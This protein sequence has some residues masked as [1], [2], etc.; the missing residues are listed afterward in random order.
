MPLTNRATL[1]HLLKHFVNVAKYKEDNKMDIGNL[2]L[3]FGPTLIWSMDKTNPGSLTVVMKKQSQLV[4]QLCDIQNEIFHDE[5][6]VDPKFAQVLHGRDSHYHSLNDLRN[7][8][9]S[10]VTKRRKTSES[11][12]RPVTVHERFVFD[13]VKPQK[14]VDPSNTIGNMLK[15]LFAKRSSPHDLAKRGI[16][17]SSQYFGNSLDQIAQRTQRDIPLF[18]E[19]IFDKL[20]TEEFVKTENLYAISGNIAE[21]QS[22]R[23]ELEKENLGVFKKNY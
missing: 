16:L 23:L 9:D 10:D 15:N 14:K 8:L 20:E 12:K 17:K 13:H 22:L 3:M 18:L 21:I 7:D 2:A 11:E 19:K 5:D 4:E 6:F 1:S